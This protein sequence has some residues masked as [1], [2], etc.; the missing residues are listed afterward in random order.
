M[1]ERIHYDFAAAL[2][3][4]YNGS[5]VRV[6]SQHGGSKEAKEGRGGKGVLHGDET[7]TNKNVDWL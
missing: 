2:I 4:S 1:S 7:S 5:C 6:F 3:R